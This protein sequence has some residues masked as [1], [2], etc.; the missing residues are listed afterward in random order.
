[1]FNT[2][3]KEELRAFKAQVEL[4]KQTTIK[5]FETQIEYNAELR[6]QIKKLK[7]RVAAIDKTL[8]PYKDPQ[9]TSFFGN[10][11]I[12]VSDDEEDA[13]WQFAN[14]MIDKTE[15]EEI[16]KEVGLEPNIEVHY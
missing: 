9:P 15:Y 4:D 6:K 3:L 1:M 8:I 16:L 7:K 12:A 10:A 2:A 11:P 13:R 14:G 5:Q